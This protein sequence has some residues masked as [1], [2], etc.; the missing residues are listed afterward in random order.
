MKTPV[1]ACENQR[2]EKAIHKGDQIWRKGFEMY[3]SGKCL[4][5]SFGHQEQ[6]INE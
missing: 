1:A 3:C 2:C 6:T 5:Q 4:F